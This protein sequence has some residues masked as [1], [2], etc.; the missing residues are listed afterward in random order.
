MARRARRPHLPPRP[1][2][3]LVEQLTP[4]TADVALA[5]L[6]QLCEPS[7]GRKPQAPLLE[8]VRITADAILQY[9]GIR[10]WGLERRLLHERVFTEMEHLRSLHFDVEKYPNGI[11][12][13]ASGT[14]AGVSWQGDRLFDI[15]KVE[16]YQES[17]FG[18]RER[19]E[20]S[21]LVRSGPVGPLVAQCPR[22]CVGRA[23]GPHPFRL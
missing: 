21:W 2:W 13:R 9:K 23:D 17:L 12:P 10:R 4:L 20:V 22:T 5:V 8:P 6:A 19:I 3:D 15:V 11:L 7:V 14:P 18:D 1:L 16:C